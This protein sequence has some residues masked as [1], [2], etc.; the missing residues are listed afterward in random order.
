[1]DIQVIPGTIQ[2]SDADAI[3]VNLFEDT[4]PGGATKAVD[5]GLGGA[6]RDLIDGGRPGR[7]PCCTRVARSRPGA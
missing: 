1:M 6:I 2:E 4:Q 7:W 5:E 3:V